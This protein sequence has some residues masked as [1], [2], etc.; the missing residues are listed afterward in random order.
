[1]VL[2]AR[3]STA[4][5][6]MSSS[7]Y[8][9]L[10]GVGMMI[11]STLGASCASSTE[12]TSASVNCV[13]DAAQSLGP[14]VN[15]SKFEGSPTVSADE[16]SLFFTSARYGQEDLFASIRADRKS[17]WGD[18]V[19]LGDSVNSS[20]GDDFS[21]RLAMDSNTLYFGSNREGGFG[22]ADLY[23]TTRESP[24]HLWS[25]ATNLGPVVNTTSFEGFPTPTADGN[26]L[27]FD[28]STTFGSQDADIWVTGRSDSNSPWSAPQRLAMPVNGPGV[29]FSPS[30]S[31]DGLS[32]Y[33]A[34]NR[35]GNLGLIDIW[36]STRKGVGDP[37]EPPRNLGPNINA[38]GAM[39]L[40][41]FISRDNNT[42]YF[43]SARPDLSTKT[44]CSPTT[45]FDQLDLY[46]ARQTCADALQR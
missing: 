28:R 20:I 41:P 3:G 44:Q 4:G 37:W 36:V 34:S 30:I 29:E 10:I 35:D 24:K 1:M 23:V 45:C 11:A 9:A 17:P 14:I 2:V 25:H 32:L 19:N 21:P 5:E 46:V 16:T 43:M 40:G 8:A 7:R 27:Y 12:R 33:F 18:P 13:F 42:L 15:S 6:H 22:A 39:T 38:A 31:A 26:T